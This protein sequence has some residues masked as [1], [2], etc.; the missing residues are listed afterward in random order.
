MGSGEVARYLGRYGSARVS[1]AMLFGAIP[2]F[3]LKRHDNP[4]G[5]D[6]QVSRTSRP[7][8]SRTATPSSR[9]SSTTST[10]WMSSRPSGSATG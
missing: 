3:L 9:S 1:K 10:T 8:S 6:G 2:P 7:R 4:E 5:V